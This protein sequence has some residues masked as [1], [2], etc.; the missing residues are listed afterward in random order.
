LKKL[1]TNKQFKIAVDLVNQ[2]K[3]FFLTGKAGTG[4]STFLKLLVKATKKKVVVLA[5]TGLS[6]INV[7]GETIHSFFRFPLEPLIDKQNQIKIFDTNSTNRKIISELEILVIDEVSMVRADVMDAIDYSLRKNG[8]NP[9]QAFGGKQ[10]IL[11]GD[12]FQLEPIIKSST[13]EEILFNNFYLGKYFFNANIFSEIKLPLVKLETVFRQQEESFISLLDRIRIDKV[14]EDDI[15]KINTRVISADFTSE[16]FI[17]TLTVKNNLA[18]EVN[19]F[20]LTKLKSKLFLFKAEFS[21]D[22]DK[23]KYPADLNLTLKEGAKVIFVKNDSN[24]RWVNGTIARVISLSNDLIRIELEDG[25]IHDVEEVTWENYKYSFDRE[26]KIIKKEY[27]GYFKQYPLKLAWAISIHKSQGLSFNKIIVDFGNGT[28]ASG[29]A[30]VALSRVTDFKGLFLKRPISRADIYVDQKV[31]D[32]YKNDYTVN[33]SIRIELNK[34]KTHLIFTERSVNQGE[35]YE[36]IGLLRIDPNRNPDQILDKA[37][38]IR[39]EMREKIGDLYN[40]YR[41]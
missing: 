1:E 9:N 19:Q 41:G 14:S 3:S 2:N 6:A 32:F 17:I 27:L 20:E 36:K 38:T 30:Y 16:N 5:P 25:N 10:I 4:K 31:I 15:D 33:S 13:G 40:V 29:Q 21:G 34:N 8:G 37:R 12:C 11:V 22:F 18:E 7:E 26:E 28:F 35:V 24:G 23:N 39:W